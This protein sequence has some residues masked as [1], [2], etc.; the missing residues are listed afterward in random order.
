MR[1][2]MSASSQQAS[3]GLGGLFLSFGLCVFFIGV[4]REHCVRVSRGLCFFWKGGVRARGESLVKATAAI[5][6]L[7]LLLSWD[8]ISLSVEEQ[9]PRF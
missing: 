4:D 9:I 3:V 8:V 5:F 1:H 2:V 7:L 6:F